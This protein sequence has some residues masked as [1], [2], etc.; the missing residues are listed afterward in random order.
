MSNTA[1]ILAERVMGWQ[2][3]E[4]GNWYTEA[5]NERSEVVNEVFADRRTAMVECMVKAVQS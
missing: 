1:K 3:T 4:F 5:G 2:L